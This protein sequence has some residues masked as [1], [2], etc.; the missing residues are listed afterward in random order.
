MAA[1]IN[2]AIKPHAGD[3]YSTASKML[4]AL[5]SASNIPPELAANTPTVNFYPPATS[6]RQTQPLYSPQKPTVIP[7]TSTPGN[8]QKPAVIIG[9]LLVGGL[10]GAVVIPNIIRQQQPET[11]IVT[12]RTPSLESCLLPHLPNRPFLP[13]LLQPQLYQPLTTTKASN[14]QSFANL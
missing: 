7:G 3:R 4:H 14:S 9:S 8:W 1:V 5:Q 13:K 10:I 2:Q 12:S 6:T 11:T